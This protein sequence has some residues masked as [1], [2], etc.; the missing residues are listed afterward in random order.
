[1]NA[2]LPYLKQI[3]DA[4]GSSAKNEGKKR[5][6]E[7]TSIA[8]NINTATVTNNNVSL[9]GNENTKGI[10]DTLAKG[11][12]VTVQDGSSQYEK[13]IFALMF[14]MLQNAMFVTVTEG[15]QQVTKGIAQL[16]KEQNESLDLIKSAL[17][18]DSGQTP[19]T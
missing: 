9:A 17:Y 15:G 18:D 3:A 12:I 13:S 19:V 16:M 1:M 14:E 8:K 6:E 11:L 5:D 2:L 4:L 7:L 10:R